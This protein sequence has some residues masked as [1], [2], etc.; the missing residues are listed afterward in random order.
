M[1]EERSFDIDSN[2]D[3]KIVK[4]LIK[5]NMKKYLYISGNGLIGKELVKLYANED[6]KII[7]LDIVNKNFSKK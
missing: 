2:I 5:E 7:V 3:L 6:V 4:F 1:P